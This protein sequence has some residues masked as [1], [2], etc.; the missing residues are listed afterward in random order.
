MDLNEC[1]LELDRIDRELVSLYC[2][3]MRIAEQVA[4]YKRAH[5]LPVLDSSREAQKLDAVAAL[6]DKDLQE[7][8]RAL[9][10][11]IMELSR[12]HQ[13]ARLGRE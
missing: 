5:S 8:V 2:E 1:R 7:S 6:A 11:K 10:E 12:A 3:R 9:Y 4:E 13:S